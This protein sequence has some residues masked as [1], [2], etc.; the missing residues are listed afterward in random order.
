MK[1]PIIGLFITGVIAAICVSFLVS[2]IRADA[3]RNMAQTPRE[4][5]VLIATQALEPL[6]VVTAD[7]VETKVVPAGSEPADAI[8]DS[9]VVIGRILT[10]PMIEGQA[11]TKAN[12][13]SEGRGFHV[14]TGLKPGMRAVAV[15]LAAHSGMEGLLYPGS[16]VD[17]LASFRL[18][19]SASGGEAVSTTLLQS[20][21][22]LAVGRLTVG[23]SEE[24]RQELRKTA[25]VRQVTLMVTPRQAEALQLA[26]SH[27]SIALTMRNPMDHQDIDQDATMLNGGRLAKLASF[28]EKTVEDGEEEEEGGVTELG[29]PNDFKERTPEPVDPKNLIPPPPTNWE[30]TIIRGTAIETRSLKVK[31]ETPEADLPPTS[32]AVD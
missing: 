12:F 18:R 4:V 16:V 30:A 10:T 9:I 8:Q 21:T 1:M 27:G 22:V 32:M 28:M 11:F 26:M 29:V 24:E 13:A 15:S 14:A 31:P 3:R 20:V 7:K 5:K 23:T 25:T 17:V 2:S 19:T 6:S